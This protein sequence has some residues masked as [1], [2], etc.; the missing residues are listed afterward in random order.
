LLKKLKFY[1]IRGTAFEL[2]KSYL[3]GRYQK[4]ILDKNSQGSNWGLIRHGVPQGSILGSLLFLLYIHDLPKSIKDN[5]KVVLFADDT[6]IFIN[7]PNQ[8]EFEITVNKVFQDITRFT[9]N[10]LSLNVDKTHFM[11]FVTK[12]SSLL[13]LNIFRGNKK[14]VNAHNTKFLGLILDNIFSWKVHIDTV[15]PK[16]SF[17]CQCD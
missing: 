7:S 2:I 16:L 8:T 9:S 11:Q 6:S 3:E 1:G 4:V 15:V 5:A 10:L 14:I 13:D 17:A 12:T